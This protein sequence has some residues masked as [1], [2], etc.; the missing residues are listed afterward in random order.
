M[1]KTKEENLMKLAKLIYEGE[2]TSLSDP[3]SV[4]VT[5]IVSDM[6]KIV[7]GCVFVCLE[8]TKFNTHLHTQE[9]SAMGVAAIIIEKGQ[10]Y[11]SGLTVPVFEVNNTHRTLAFMWSRYYGNPQNEMIMTGITGTNGKTSTAYMLAETL[12]AAGMKC[13]LIGTVNC[14]VDKKPFLSEEMS[15]NAENIKTMTTPDPH[16]LYKILRKMRDVGVKYVVMEVSSHALYYDK[17]AP[18]N[19]DIGIFT[20]LSSEHMDFHVTMDN[21]LRAKAKLFSSCKY[22]VINADDKYAGKITDACRAEIA[23]CSADGRKDSTIIATNI[24]LDGCEGIKYI[25]NSPHMR[26]AVKSS[27]PGRFTVYNSMLAVSAAIRLGVSPLIAQDAVRN[28]RGIDGRMEKL[29]I[30]RTLHNFSVFIDYAHTEEALKNL[31][32]TV[33]SFKKDGERTVLL[34]G[35]GGDRD[36]TKRMPIGRVAAESADF[37]IITSDNSRSEDPNLIIDDILKG[38]PADKPKK[39]IVSRESAI[40]YAIMNAIDND[41]ILLVG[42][43]HEKYEITSAGH[44]RFDEREIVRKALEEAETSKKHEN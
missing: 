1:I 41:I 38:V 15:E 30:D 21:Y 22:A 8:G 9:I 13:G 3:N 33:N 14:L 4:D 2:Y 43:G 20:N 18:I 27:V 10:Q 11:Q 42:K 25:Y 32:T 28:I 19:Y 23:T 31:M 44:R 40:R 5:D 12:Y 29:K 34:F 7:K 26:F 16:M 35:C 6:R 37:L 24:G 36:R 39:V 17:T